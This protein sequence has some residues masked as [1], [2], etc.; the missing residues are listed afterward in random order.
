MAADPQAKQFMLTIN[1]PGAEETHDKIKERLAT[2]FKTFR[3]CAICDEIGAN[4]TKHT[5]VAVCFD[6]SVRVSTVKKQFP[7]AH[8]DIS[9][10]YRSTLTYLKKEGR[11]ANSPKAATS[12]PGSY[13]EFGTMPPA[14]A[15]SNRLLDDMY[16]MVVEEELRNTEII[17][18]NHDYSNMIDQMT[19]LRT[20]FLQDKYKKERRLDLRTIYIFGDTGTG[21]S[22]GI[23][24]KHGDENVYRVTDY[25]HP[26]DHY[27]LED[28]IVF[29]EFRS[30]L[31]VGDMLKYLDIYGITLPARYVSKYA[32]YNHA[33]FATNI[34]LEEQY[35]EI[36]KNDQATWF[37]FLRRIHEVHEYKAGGDII[38]YASVDEYFK[39]R[40]IQSAYINRNV[41]PDKNGFK[42]LL[43]TSDVPFDEEDK[44]HGKTTSNS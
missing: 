39:A 15:G 17:R 38:K 22:R 6:S 2:K 29:E 8:I 23:L 28:C 34:P 37:A 24:D 44:D 26:F 9:R 43:D 16:R 20:L 5:H 21:K 7:R 42:Q 32:C 1:N 12:V 25:Q 3:H 36:Q 4:G 11:H 18:Q 13:E 41:K 30:S 40:K 14:N 19:K 31:P 27:E 10:N 33:Y 35:S